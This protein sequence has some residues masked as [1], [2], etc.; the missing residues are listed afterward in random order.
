MPFVTEGHKHCREGWLNLTCPFCTGNPGYHLGF[1][2]D[3]E[4]FHCWRCGGHRII[5]TLSKLSNQSP[6]QIKFLLKQYGGRTRLPSRLEPIV[7]VKAFKF[8]S[9]CT[10]LQ[11]YHR[12]Y[13]LSRKFDP[14]KLEKLWELKGTGPIAMLDKSD[15]KLR[16]I[17]PI[18]WDNK[19]VSFQGRAI[20]NAATMRYK[21]C[22]KSRE[23][24]HHQHILY[25]KQEYWG[26]IGICV[27]GIT[28]VWR[29]GPKAFGVFGISYTKQQVKE[30]RKRFTRVAVIFD[31]D[32][33]A[34]K[35]ANKLIGELRYYGVN[36]WK[37]DI[38]GDPGALSDNE[39]EYLIKQVTS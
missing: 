3:E 22:P 34:Q 31:D 26:D 21:A 37:I 19:I 6:E 10:E 25:G 36:A 29:M 1:C 27:E 14:D 39:A 5:E 28:D 2:I 9:N 38:I 11:S 16:I 13:L 15:Y 20:S 7:R 30:I 4:Y 8:P 33:Q 35:Q 17:A 23:L 32:L 24:I 18:Y 12:Q